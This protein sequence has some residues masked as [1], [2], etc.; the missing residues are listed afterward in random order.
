LA[1]RDLDDAAGVMARD[2]PAPIAVVLASAD[3]RARFRTALEGHPAV[4]VVDA[5]GVVARLSED[6]DRLRAL[7]SDNV[8]RFEHRVA[9][10]RQVRHDA[11]EGL[12]TATAAVESALGSLD[13]FDR[14]ERDLEAALAHRDRATAAEAAQARHL[15]EVLERR[16]RLA[17][18]RLDAIGVI[19]QI[20]A[21]GPV[22]RSPDL[23]RRIGE[24]EA[25][26]ARADAEQT[27]AERAAEASLHQAREGRIMAAAEL[28]RA[29]RTLRSELPGL[30]EVNADDWPPGPL[31]PVLVGERRER[32][33]GVLAERYAA[34]SATRAALAGAT[35]E[36]RAAEADLD[37]VRHTSLSQ[38]MASI[39]EGLLA[40]GLPEGGADGREPIVVCDEP[41]AGI[42]AAAITPILERLVQDR[43]VQIIYLTDDARTAAWAEELPPTLGGLSRPLAKPDSATITPL[44]PPAPNVDRDSA[45]DASENASDNRPVI[46]HRLT[47]APADQELPHVSTYP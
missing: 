15:A 12:A 36:L 42:D 25:A 5:A 9:R 11:G 27:R 37:Q 31:L 4:V 28:E 2:L 19:E 3:V 22:R 45:G 41:F 23:R 16:H 34:T 30:P 40:A 21:G 7:H 17:Q 8:A 47:S 29:D 44:R 6:R 43:T 13:D 38:G 20:E 10:L 18:Q 35:K 39:L 1:I 14:A 24:M 33:A 26:L 46:G 32:I